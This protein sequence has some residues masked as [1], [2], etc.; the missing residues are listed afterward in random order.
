MLKKPLQTLRYSMVTAPCCS[1][2]RRYSLFFPCLSGNLTP[3]RVRSSA[4]MRRRRALRRSGNYA[5]S[6]HRARSSMRP[7]ARRHGRRRHQSRA[8]RRMR[9]AQY[10]FW[11]T[12]RP[13]RLAQRRP[14][15]RVSQ[16]RSDV[17]RKQIPR[18]SLA[19]EG[20][21]ELQREPNPGEQILSGTDPFVRAE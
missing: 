21:G 3:R 14:T 18:V 11:L 6:H 16:A 7:D 4:E 15:S 20:K 17:R 5:R 13:R 12:C 19:N 9:C 8:A 2:N 1:R 10:L